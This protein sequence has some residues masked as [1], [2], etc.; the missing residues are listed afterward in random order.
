M[1]DFAALIAANW[2]VM[3][4]A[5]GDAATY[6]EGDGTATTVTVIPDLRTN[7]IELDVTWEVAAGQAV[8]VPF[9]PRIL[10]GVVM[11]LADATPLQAVRPISA[12]ADPAP[13]LDGP[14]IA[15]ARWMSDEYLAPLWDG[16]ACCL[17]SGYG[18]KAVTMV[19]PVDIPPLLPAYPKDQ[20]ILQYIAANG[21]VS[22]E[23]EPGAAR[24]TDR[25][26]E[27][28][29]DSPAPAMAHNRAASTTGDPNQSPPSL[30]ASPVDNPI[31]IVTGDPLEASRPTRRCMAIA[32][33]TASTALGNAAI[34]PSPVFFTS[35]PAWF[36]STSFP[37]TIRSRSQTYLRH[38][39]EIG[40]QRDRSINPPLA[41][42]SGEDGGHHHGCRS[43][44][45][46]AIGGTP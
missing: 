7:G 10:Q 14:H 5:F 3:E 39:A 36:A 23:V 19:S 30:A 46:I 32:Q 40:R 6:T 35:V 27:L 18:Q 16:V 11:A 43:N 42:Y 38:L 1:S 41:R 8:F 2:P 22:I 15:L 34:K 44:S 26:I 29:H 17:P 37:T 9:G 20:C 45:S 25:T 13:V 31:R 4:A 12:V 33:S 21:R 28:A 24:D